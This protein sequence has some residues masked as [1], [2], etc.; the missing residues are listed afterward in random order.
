MPRRANALDRAIWKEAM[1]QFHAA[2]QY[3]EFIPSAEPGLALRFV[4]QC[5]G[6][7]VD[8]LL[9]VSLARPAEAVIESQMLDRMPL[10]YPYSD[11]FLDL[12]YEA[13]ALLGL[14]RR[15]IRPENLSA[16]VRAIDERT[17]EVIAWR[18]AGGSEGI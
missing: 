12:A 1:M 11:R 17:L 2:R 13:M 5:Q 10:A 8:R 9:S 7:G 14:D 4:M 15:S 16:S 6:N 3:T 18:C